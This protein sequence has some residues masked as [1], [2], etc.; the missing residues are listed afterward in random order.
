MNA[1]NFFHLDRPKNAKTVQSSTSIWDWGKQLTRLSLLVALPTIGLLSMPA[2]GQVA[3]T[4]LNPL[5]AAWIRSEVESVDNLQ[6]QISGSDAAIMGGTIEK[7]TVSGENL[8]YQGFHVSRVKLD[9]EGIQLNVNEVVQG[10]GDL[11]LLAPVPVR[12][13]MQLTEADLNQTL[14]TPLVQSQLAQANVR[15]PIGGQS[16]PFQIN[17]PSVEVEAD[18]LRIGANVLVPGGGP[19]PVTLTTGLEARN[20]NELILIEPQWISQGETIP[21]PSLNNLPIQLD[22]TVQINRLELQEGQILYDGNLTITPE[23]VSS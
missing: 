19:V 22:Q 17:D 16:V 2:F 21:V 14:R 5:V 15:L 18:L 9:G 8:R 6:V 13:R 4:L 20:G 1:M 11:K 12:V 3:S 10:G 7:A 23:A